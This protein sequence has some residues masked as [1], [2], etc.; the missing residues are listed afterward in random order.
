[1]PIVFINGISLEETDAF[2]LRAILRDKVGVSLCFLDICK[3][4]HLLYY[5]GELIPVSSEFKYSEYEDVV[6][7]YKKLPFKY[8][9][10]CKC[11]N[12]QETEIVE[13]VETNKQY[14]MKKAKKNYTGLVRT[15]EAV[16][17]A[18][19]DHPNII[20][21][22]EVF[23]NNG[24]LFMVQEYAPYGDL[25]E[26]IGVKGN[27]LSNSYNSIISQVIEGLTYLHSKGYAHLDIK[28]D[29]I[30][31]LSLDPVRVAF[32]DFELSNSVPH[33][34]VHQ[35]GTFDYM[36]P[37]I[38][39]RSTDR[40]Y[41]YDKDCDVWML[42][43]IMVILFHNA[44]YHPFGST[45]MEQFRRGTENPLIL[46]MKPYWPTVMPE[47]IKAIAKAIFVERECRPTL[48]TVRDLFNQC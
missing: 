29:N 6:S 23:M 45:E 41:I 19:C 7:Q 2:K 30:V 26:F 14:I 3:F 31:L 36:P 11:I 10:V 46:G 9:K 38:A 44:Q 25:F 5:A 40:N 4:T 33:F 42:G 32:I 17:L 48:E 47:K 20:K 39:K 21:L 13:H 35:F 8:R 16:I 18:N 24:E 27:D 28:L 15:M 12:I 34:A 37:E 22:H 43:V 1:M